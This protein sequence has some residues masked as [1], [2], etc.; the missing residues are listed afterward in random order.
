MRIAVFG[1]GYVGVVSA[2]C[3]AR[4]GHQI[5]GVDPQAE[6]VALV[7]AGQPPII[8][9]GVAG[10][11][12]DAVAAGRLRATSDPAEAVAATEMSLVCV[13]TPSR[14]NGSLD[15]GAVER[16]CGQIGAA[17]AAAGKPH[18]VVMRST[19][20]PGTMRGLVIPALEAAAGGAAALLK[21]A[22]NPEFLRE[23]TAVADYDAPP[24][25]V[26]GAAEPETAA[27]VMALYERIPGPKFAT[28][29]EIAEMVKYAD[30]AWH[31]AKVAFGN[32]IGNIAKAL[33]I[34]SHKV[35]EIFCEDRKLNI[36]PAYL[37][38]GFAFGGSCLPKDLRA[39]TYKGR[40]LDLEL[41]VLESLMR[42][43]AVQIDRAVER[44]LET[45]ARRVAMLGISFKA[46][47]DDLRE[48]PQVALVERLIG[49]GL[50]LRI[51]DRNVHLARLVGANRAYIEDRIPHISRLLSEDLAG[52]AAHGELVILGNSDPEFR[53]LPELLSPGQ[54]V[55]DLVRLAGLEAIG[56]GYDGVNW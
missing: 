51:Y 26:V 1:L 53:R 42:S 43:N 49:K 35:M 36:S 37:R 29:L 10:L 27:A 39:L 47:T 3:L 48:S 40:E 16:V 13:G 11:V 2:A 32:E 28:E 52:V 17:V 22:N 31:A 18:L 38:P 54:R 19:V 23:S 33:D 5:I 34:D 30:N 20:L 12:A 56:A 45:G 6:K 14:R 41:P 50:D 8:E 44:V 21:I 7:N 46:G 4:D 25:T 15:T 55:L 9:A 24:K